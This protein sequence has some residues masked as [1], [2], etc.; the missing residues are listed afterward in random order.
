MNTKASRILLIVEKANSLNPIA[1]HKARQTPFGYAKGQ[2]ACKAK[3]EHESDLLSCL[4]QHNA[5][6]IAM[7]EET[8]SRPIEIVDHEEKA[9]Y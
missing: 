1:R 3:E 8:H 7:I 9:L 2:L 6:C 5:E 4:F